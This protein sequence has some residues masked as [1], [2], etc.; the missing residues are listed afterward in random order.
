MEKKKTKNEV[1]EVKEEKNQISKFEKV[2]NI[3]AVLMKGIINYIGLILLFGILIVNI[4]LMGTVQNT[5]EKVLYRLN[6]VHIAIGVFLMLGL[7][8]FLVNKVKISTKKLLLGVIGVNIILSALFIYMTKTFQ[9]SDQASV[10]HVVKAV[11]TGKGL[12]S[13]ISYIQWYP[14]QLGLVGYSELIYTITGGINEYKLQALNIIYNVIII[15]MLYKIT[16]IIYKNDK[17][18]RVVI[19]LS[20]LFVHLVMFST[21]VYG[22]IPGLA[23]TLVSVYFLFKFA[24]Q[25][26]KIKWILLASI[27]MGIAALLRNNY[28]VFAIAEFIYLGIYLVKTRRLKY[29]LAMLVLIVLTISPMLVVKGYY[30]H[31]L[32][33]KFNNGI[34]PIAFMYMGA[35]GGWSSNGWYNGNA[36]ALY[37]ENNE[38][39]K[40][41]AEAGKQKLL[42]RAIFFLKNPKEFVKFYGEKS[43][44][45]WAE[46]THEALYSNYLMFYLEHED[47]EKQ[48]QHIRSNKILGSLYFGKLRIG[49]EEYAKVLAIVMYLGIVITVIKNRN[50]LDEEKVALVLMFLGGFFFHSLWEGKSRYVFPYVV[51]MIPLSVSAI[52]LAEGI[53]RKKEEQKLDGEKTK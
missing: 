17:L 48:E 5:P 37:K 23:F 53:F 50:K 19:I 29:L 14:H 33:R 34:P 40:K 52:Y 44:S 51:A 1:I 49:F 25:E 41:I 7:I 4:L 8:V 12:E 30:E 43:A 27:F 11:M 6:F 46:S 35:F 18:N 16:D 15:F 9:V 39:Q 47:T 2:M 31:R 28:F 45:Q 24:K 22:D 32:D 38:D 21:F 26:Q 3:L 42:E 36:V 13:V 20:L 10:Q